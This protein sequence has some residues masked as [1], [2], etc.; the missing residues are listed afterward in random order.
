[1]TF[2][3][4]ASSADQEFELTRDETGV[5]EYSVKASVFS[6]VSQLCIHFPTNFGADTT[7]IYYIGLRGDFLRVNGFTEFF[8][9]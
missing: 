1:M 8:F 5:V 9:P 3:E 2:D 4:A 6:S 7:K